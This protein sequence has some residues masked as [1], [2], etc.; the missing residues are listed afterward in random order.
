MAYKVFAKFG[1]GKMKTTLGSVELKEKVDVANY[2]KKRIIP[3][4][5][6][7]EVYDTVTKETIKGKRNKFWLW[8]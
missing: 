2:V 6:N 7:I 4:T 3:T 1:K 8:K 5:T